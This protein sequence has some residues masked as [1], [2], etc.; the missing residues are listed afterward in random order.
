MGTET[1]ERLVCVSKIGVGT[2]GST[3]VVFRHIEGGKLTEKQALFDA[4]TKNIKKAMRPFVGGVY[5]VGVETNDDGS[6]G[7]KLGTAEY[8]GR[9]EDSDEVARWQATERATQAHDEAKKRREKDGKHDAVLEALEPLREA[10]WALP[11]PARVH[12][13]A[14]AVERITRRKR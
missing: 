9:W 12:L 8:V 3:L 7:W 5:D 13:L 10:Y 2:K 6:Q 1:T 14:Q 11:A 4:K